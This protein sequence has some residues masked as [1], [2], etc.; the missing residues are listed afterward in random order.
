[1]TGNHVTDYGFGPGS[2]EGLD[3]GFGDTLGPEADDA[4]RSGL[5]AR[6]ELVTITAPPIAAVRRRALRRRKRRGVIQGVGGLAATCAVIAGIV[7]WSPGREAGDDAGR[8]LG[9]ATTVASTTPS[10]TVPW[11][12][13][14]PIPASSFLQA[15]DLGSGWKGPLGSPDVRTALTL[16]GD[17]CESTGVYQAQVPVAPAVDR[18]FEQYSPSGNRTNEAWE[19]I[20]TFAPGAGA[21]VMR[22]VRAALTIGCGAPQ[23][24]KILGYPST[25][26]D[27]AI[28]FTVGGDS[29]NLL[30]RSGDRVAS[31]L[32]DTV[33]SGQDGSTSMDEL[34]KQM[35]IRLTAA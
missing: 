24:V 15:S 11:D 23:F 26:A 12:M 5:R 1:M 35:A 31:A 4:L 9:G 20:Y 29:R 27:E 6:A 2:G 22:K 8:R 32:L 19:A 18:Y 30:V 33:P 17:H 25:T 28:V 7:A 21:A 13:S 34:A 10:D 14:R 16:D 3:S